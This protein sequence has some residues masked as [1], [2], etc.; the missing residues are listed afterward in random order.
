MAAFF[1]PKKRLVS[2]PRAVFSGCD[3]P[4]GGGAG[5]GGGRVGR[6]E[7]EERLGARCGGGRVGRR[8]E[9]GPEGAHREGFILSIAKA[10]A[11]HV[12]S[13]PRLSLVARKRKA[14]LC[15]STPL[16]LR[17]PLASSLSFPGPCGSACAAACW[18]D[19]DRQRPSGS[20]CPQAAV[21]D[22]GRQRPSGSGCPQAAAPLHDKSQPNPR[23]F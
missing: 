3:G 7:G 6:R 20:G 5:R 4:L 2:T 8:E 17:R 1:W 23:L 18:L 14:P 15:S 9:R 11:G 13:F 10:R 21:Q 12:V 19:G 22:G 16:P